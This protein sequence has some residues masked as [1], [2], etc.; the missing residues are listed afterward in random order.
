MFSLYT[1]QQCTKCISA[2]YNYVVSAIKN[3][4]NV[5]IE[6]L[7]HQLCLHFKEHKCD[8]IKNR[9]EKRGRCAIK[10]VAE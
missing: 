10:Y 6:E 9:L 4:L 7:K 1:S 2:W 8:I 3:I 5:N